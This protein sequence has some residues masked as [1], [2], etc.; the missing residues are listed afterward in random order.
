MEVSWARATLEPRDWLDS[1]PIGDSEVRVHVVEDG[2]HRGRVL[3][4]VEIT[5]DPKD[6]WQVMTDCPSASSYLPWVVH[7]ERVD[8]HDADQSEIFK[9][10]IKFAWY[11]PQLQHTFALDYYP[12]RQIDFQRLSGSPQRFSG[13]WWLQPNN[14]SVLVIYSI[15]MEPGF[16][17]PRRLALRILRRQLPA[18]LNAL[19]QR[20]E[21]RQPTL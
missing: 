17:V 10:T 18:G 12:F 9:Q 4:A 14:D 2:P 19:R 15:D 21:G 16:L 7:C 13:S 1:A 11:L 8:S 6:I 3:A 20:V 5:A